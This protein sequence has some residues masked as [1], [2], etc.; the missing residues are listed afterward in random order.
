MD[1]PIVRSLRSSVHKDPPPRTR[2]LASVNRCA[3]TRTFIVGSL[4]VQSLGNK[5][6]AVS[7]AIIDN[8]CDLFATVE[9]W[10]DSADSPS[11]VASTPPGY[12]VLERA[13][14]RVGKAVRSLKTNHGGI[15][16]FVRSEL[17]VRVIAFPSYKSF[18]LL[19]LFVRS[20]A[21]SFVFVV[22]YR[23]DP[24]SAV[25]DSFFTEWADV[26]ER[27]SAFSACLIVG[28]INLHLNDV[29]DTRSVR[30]HTLSCSF[31][32]SDHV[33]QPT[34]AGNQ[35][36]ILL[37]RLDQ[38]APVVR[39]DP[40]M[41]SD[42]SL[43]VAFFELVDSRV[44]VKSSIKRRPWRSFD[45]DAFAVDLEKSDLILHPP[46]DVTELF[47][48]YDDT[49]IRL[50]DKHA[51]LRTVKVKARPAAPWFDLECRDAK[52]KT[53][54]LEK[55]YR[56]EPTAETRAGW[57]SQFAI[58][59]AL[60]QQK[61]ISH[62]STAISSCQRDSK[63]LWSKLRP[64]LQSNTAPT[65]HLT[66]SEHARFFSE[67]IEGIRSSTA[68]AAPPRIEYRFVT[69]H[70]SA[71]QPAT[72][73]EIATILNRSMAKQCQLDP[74]P[75]WLIK[76]SSGIL[77]PV[78]T[79]MC[80]A[81][82]QQ[83]ALPTRC[84]HAIVRPLLKKSSLDPNDPS[85]Y[86]PISNLSFL[87]KIVEKVVDARLSNHTS[88]QNLLPLFQSAY[89]PFHSTET[90]VICVVNSML[91]VMDQGHVGALMLLDLSAA[92]DTV[93][94]RILNDVMRRRFGVCG[95]ALDWLADFLKDRTQ[96]VRAGGGESSVSKLKFGVPQGSVN[97][98]K[99][100]IE[101]S[102][103]ITRQ[104]LK[105][106]LVHHLFADDTQGMLHCAPADVRQMMS[107]LNDCFVDVGAWC[108]SKRLQLNADKTELL[109][110]GTAAN[111]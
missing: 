80:N 1:I 111:L 91:K 85:S 104:L 49:L 55:A 4:N 6:A 57:R 38:P 77:A 11:V 30:F 47:A 108:A 58:Q 53:R 92:F 50:L 81:S 7:H 10:H 97:G 88:K 51:P 33:G 37:W 45:Y 26:L 98:P 83:S 65:P 61:F 89:R 42:H 8:K 46:T 66:A 93:D 44:T 39:V 67:K 106:D 43:I 56:R 40:P 17:Q 110:F 36:D 23:P 21:T 84:K 94:H 72:T 3:V 62:W 74:A 19:P 60:F 79:R 68:A 63:A 35:L 82:F 87:S 100:F 86:R 28:D 95:S 16:V 12:R 69:E 9:S 59:R 78:I 73:E 2:V 29:T 75:T 34:R 5:S 101:Y 76:R 52:A 25:T 54:R 99:R 31:N 22:V 27:T 103:D 18:E 13:R 64:L 20:G 14:P 71:F 107:T 24:A 15:C 48:C 32:L 105:Y 102:E 41:L 90:A 96:I 70:L 109:L